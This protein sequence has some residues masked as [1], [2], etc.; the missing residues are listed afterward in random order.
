MYR[1]QATA[2]QL[3]WNEG[4]RHTTV[5]HLLIVLNA[6]DAVPIGLVSALPERGHQGLGR[7]HEARTRFGSGGHRITH[8]GANICG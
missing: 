8:Q 2:T 6:G 5:E 1:L 4:G 7:R 3:F